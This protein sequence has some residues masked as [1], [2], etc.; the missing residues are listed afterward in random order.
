LLRIASSKTCELV[1]RSPYPVLASSLL[2]GSDAVVR[3][4]AVV[5]G[6]GDSLKSGSR[7]VQQRRQGSRDEPS[8]NRLAGEQVSANIDA[9][10]EA[11]NAAALRRHL[12]LP[13]ASQQPP[14]ARP[15]KAPQIL[16]TV[17]RKHARQAQ[18]KPR[19]WLQHA[20]NLRQHVIRPRSVL[21]HLG[22]EDQ[23]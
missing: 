20:M 15:E 7:Q 19:S 8:Q 17:A 10:P 1:H 21:Q 23:V 9:A 22:A 13:E 11:D 14:D 2:K 5:L 12:H 16:L 18:Q 4:E 3:G 6:V